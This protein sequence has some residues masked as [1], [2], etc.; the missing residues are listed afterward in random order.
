[1]LGNDEAPV[2]AVGEIGQVTVLIQ[3][4]GNDSDLLGKGK[5]GSTGL[6]PQQPPSGT[7]LEDPLEQLG[8]L[9][10]DVLQ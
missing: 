7:A 8:V 5:P 9:V 10:F 6:S 3:D 4:L 2:I 1:V